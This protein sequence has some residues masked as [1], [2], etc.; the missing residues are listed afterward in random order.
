MSLVSKRFHD[1]VTTP[2]AWRIAF[3]RYF[4]GSESLDATS[5]DPRF[6]HD[7]QQILK[8]DRRAFSRLNAL[9]SWRSEY[10]LRTRLLR[11]LA[12]GKP[13]QFQSLARAGHPRHGS[14][15]Q[16]TAVTTYGS[17]LV[18]PVS[19]LHATFGI[20][21]NK[22]QPLFIHGASE[23]GIATA[24]DPALAKV[25][26]WGVNDHQ[27]FKHFADLYIGDAEY[28]LG[29]GEVV[30]MPNVM[31][32]SQQYGKVYGEACPGGRVFY[33][34]C[35]E[36]RGRFLSMV[37]SP[38]HDLGIPE[39]NM[40]GCAVTSVWIAKNDTLLKLTS[41]IFGMLAGFSN[42]VLTAYALGSNPAYDRRYEK[43]EPT[44]KWVLSP[45]VP[46]VSIQVDEQYSTRRQADG[47]IWAVVLNA[48]GE[49]FFLTDLP[50][51][52][53]T[54]P[55]L[56][57]DEIDRVA[58]K[59]GRSCQW[60]LI[61][62]TRRV[63]HSN[64]FDS[65]TVDGSYTPRSSSDSIGLGSEQLAAETK[66][67]ERFLTY[68][69]KHFLKICEGWDMRRILQV[70]FAGDDRQ[71]ASES[72]LVI[73]CGLSEDSS[74]SIRRFVRRK[75]R[76]S[77][78]LG[79]DPFPAIQT[80][81]RPSLFGG[82]RVS[83]AAADASPS[84]K[85]TS[86]SRTSS[87]GD[88]RRGS[89]RTEWFISNF[90]FGG[91]RPA[92]V[93]ASAVDHSTCSVLTT[94]EDPLL[95]MNGGSSASSPMNSPLQHDIPYSSASDIPGQRARFLAVGLMTGI[96]VLWDMRSSIPA[97]SDMVNSISPAR[98]IYTDSPQ[99]SC[100]A[101]TSL[102]V[103]HGGNDGLV[104]AWDPLAS[105]LQPIRTLNSRFSSRARRRLVQA[106]MSTHGVGNNYYAAGAV[107]LDPDPTVLRGMV[108]LGTHLRY[109]SYS[110]SAADQFKSSKRRLR[111]RSERGSN[112]AHN[113]Q[114][115]T[116]TG[117]GALQDYIA[118]ER[119]EIEREKMAKRKEEELLSG[120]F[121]TDLLGPG[122][123]EEELLAYATMLS[124]ESYSTD[125]FKRRGSSE[126]SATVSSISND[127]VP[128]HEA[129]LPIFDA[130]SSK[131]S[132]LTEAAADPD[133]DPEIAEAI[134][135]SLL[136]QN[137]ASGQ[138]QRPTSGT[139]FNPA[140][141][142]PEF[143]NEV[144]F[145]YVQKGSSRRA[146]ATAPQH[147]ALMDPQT[148]KQN[149][150]QEETDLEFALRLS[151]AEEESRKEQKSQPR[152]AHFDDGDDSPKDRQNWQD[153]D[154][155]ALEHSDTVR[156]TSSSGKGN[157]KGKQRAA[158]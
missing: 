100:V 71:G 8:S 31:D 154:Y 149:P 127:T 146:H 132:P 138:P 156:E 142:P 120:R 137:I 50:N 90:D 108:S 32:L 86:R 157:G 150:D 139:T 126:A 75:F 57:A 94:T 118:N 65:S 152:I 84:P 4:V 67:I 68:R 69:P 63:A 29:N 1:L 76:L 70:D 37:S 117:R 78:E 20:G 131:S 38:H 109:W 95:S 153:L 41:G 60:T 44:A 125:E 61:E 93:T 140:A 52:P 112:A 40:I 74:S 64:P 91:L 12:R 47:R 143:S 72:I 111:R 80:Q 79:L 148:T 39:I 136:D 116:H 30:G 73:S 99:I 97:A 115:F 134:R 83:V 106:E 58:W 107:V 135:L 49:V 23:Q 7:D 89:F 122:A 55:K 98:I 66:E 124:E 9:A 85:S 34:S 28:G 151:L 114:R 144:P 88:V 104:Q 105:T 141:A 110:S 33:T 21:L 147:S 5:E 155:P 27:A 48:L 96:V 46:I 45:G 59:T 92:Q 3:S 130:P 54:K 51:R 11:S 81:K 2:H 82:R 25:D 119:A 87:P 62:A 35:G 26:H 101:L 121:G 13:A 56:T 113:E 103:V 36:Q 16:A 24:S 133:M 14:G 123:S 17:N 43:G 22:K 19:H 102:Y 128:A 158:W 77:P 15:T 18:Y 145:R 10:I 42:G 53:E 6:A 129:S